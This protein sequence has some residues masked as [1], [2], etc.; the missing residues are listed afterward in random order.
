MPCDLRLGGGAVGDNVNFASY[1]SVNKGEK[2]H[3]GLVL[4]VKVASYLSLSKGEKPDEGL[5]LSGCSA[6]A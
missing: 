6:L 4:S 3:E 5:V 2:P 1:L